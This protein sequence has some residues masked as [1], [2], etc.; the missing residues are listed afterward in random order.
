MPSVSLV[1]GAG[2]ARGYAHIGVINQLVSR[3]YNIVSISGSSMGALVGGVYAAG[4]LQVYSD[5]VSKLRWIDVVRL[6]D[7]HFR[8]GTIR[9]DKV[10]QHIETLIG[11][12]AIEDLPLHYTAVATDLCGQKEVWFQKGALLDA[13]RA[14]SAVPGVFTPI[15]K[16]GQILVD[17]G[18]LNPLPIIPTVAVKADLIVA[19]DLNASDDEVSD[20]VMPGI[21]HLLTDRS[22]RTLSR[23][24]VVMSSMEVMLAAL[25]R[26]KVAGY[27]PDM[28]VHIPKSLA[29]F[30]EF[31]R[32][33][34]LIDLGWRIA[35]KQLD[36]LEARSYDDFR[37]E[38]RYS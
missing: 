18:V 35:A 8:R 13:I 14:S 17:G 9:G 2:G 31:H 3:G 24:G 22:A 34:E 21:R 38:D 33:A 20:A 23:M 5:W 25:S 27:P 15:K 1:L 36:Q 29:G 28:V 16:A 30:H 12:P 19:V 11:N 32:A 6:L 26:Y 37:A 7:L 10:F 4:G